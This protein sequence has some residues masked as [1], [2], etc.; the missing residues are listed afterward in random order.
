MKIA[1]G[2]KNLYL[3]PTRSIQTLEYPTKEDMQT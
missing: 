2:Q 3:F 1:R